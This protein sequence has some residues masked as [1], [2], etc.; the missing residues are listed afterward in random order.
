[1]SD[2]VIQQIAKDISAMAPQIARAR[3]LIDI[4]KEAGMNVS[5]MEAELRDMIVQKDKWTQV[6]KTRGYEVPE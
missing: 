6:L 2:P 1:M 4:S 5:T 3:E